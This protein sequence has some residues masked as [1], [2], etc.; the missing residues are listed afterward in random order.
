MDRGIEQDKNINLIV[1]TSDKLIK[2][3][4]IPFWYQH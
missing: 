3:V 1:L 2:G 4:S